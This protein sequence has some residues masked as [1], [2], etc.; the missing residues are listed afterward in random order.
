MSKRW[1]FAGLSLFLSFFSAPA[2]NGFSDFERISL[3]QGLSQT[4]IF[5]IAQDKKGFLWFGTQ[6]GL[7]RF[8]GYSFR[9]FRP[10]RTDP[11]SVAD[12]WI[13][14]LYTDQQG[15]FWVGTFNSGLQLYNPESGEFKSFLFPGK[16]EYPLVQNRIWSLVDG[17][18]G[19]LWVGTDHGLQ[20]FDP[21]TGNSTSYHPG[22]HSFL[23]SA[24]IL[25][26]YSDS[27][28]GNLWIGSANGL[29]IL[30]TSD[31]TFT[32]FGQGAEKLTDGTV[33]SLF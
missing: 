27:L 10:D 26:L 12:H 24:Q 3:D 31:M 5:S 22:S 25:T 15:R 6:D 9:V 11:S 17:K 1:L 14:S 30:N 29:T 18:N 23:Q 28:S 19:H 32:W 4:T 20:D 13:N 7:N 33:L 2:Q 21:E 8:D 16:D